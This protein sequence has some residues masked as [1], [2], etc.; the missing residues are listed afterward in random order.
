M[1][2]KLTAK[3]QNHIPARGR[4]LLSNG[5][6]HASRSYFKTISPQGDGNS[7]HRPRNTRSYYDFKT[8]SP[9]GDGNLLSFK[10]QHK[11]RHFK[12]ISPQGDGNANCHTGTMPEITISKPY[13]RK[14]TERISSLPCQSGGAV[15]VSQSH[16]A[17]ARVLG[18]FSH[19]TCYPISCAQGLASWTGQQGDRVSG[20][21][22]AMDA[23]CKPS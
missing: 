3:F 4:K 14:G 10:K 8:I 5:T 11:T 22:G 23:S 2:P 9:Q 15:N 18:T 20:G 12:T 16:F 13:P 6:N 17:N 21:G 7:H 1:K 19:T